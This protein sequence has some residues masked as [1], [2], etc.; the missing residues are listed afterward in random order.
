[1][2]KMSVKLV[3]GLAAILVVTAMSASAAVIDLTFEGVGPIPPPT[4]RKSFSFTTVAPAALD[5]ADRTSASLFPQ[6]AGH[7]PE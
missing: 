6:C 1:M 4:I 2:K 5:L 3:A 7:L